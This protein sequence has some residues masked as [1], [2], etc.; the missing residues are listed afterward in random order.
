MK[1]SSLFEDKNTHTLTTSYSAPYATPAPNTLPL[2]YKTELK[3]GDKRT[4][5]EL[6]FLMLPL[7]MF[8][9]AA[10]NICKRH[11][12][13]N[14]NEAEMNNQT[15]DNVRLNSNGLRALEAVVANTFLPP[16]PPSPLSALSPFEQNDA[17][18]SPSLSASSSSETLGDPNES[19]RPTS[20]SQNLNS[21]SSR[22]ESR[23]GRSI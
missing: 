15:H 9:I 8:C 19:F 16:S 3:S 21:N 7:A 6:I 23:A 17:S 20:S 18:Q 11:F 10:I 2:L 4:P 22:E 1:N 14:R 12:R 13:S 5:A